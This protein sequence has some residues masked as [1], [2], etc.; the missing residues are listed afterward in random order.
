[1]RRVTEEE[2]S[3]IA[4]EILLSRVKLTV[5]EKKS[6]FFKKGGD[7]GNQ[8]GTPKRELAKKSLGYD[9]V[10]KYC[11]NGAKVHTFASKPYGKKVK[12]LVRKSSNLT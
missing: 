3:R 12:V 11:R 9:R 1:M 7:D 5:P 10:T 4:G 2:R 6:Y 8:G